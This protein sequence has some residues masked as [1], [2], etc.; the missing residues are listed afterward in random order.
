MHERQA[1]RRS[2]VSGCHVSGC[3]AHASVG[4]LIATLLT[5]TPA[6]AHQIH[7]FANTKGAEIQGELYARGGQPIRDARVRAISPSGETLG[8]TTTDAQGKFT[9]V[10]G[11]RCD[12]RLVA[13]S[14]DGHET[15]YTVP[16]GE[17]PESLPPYAAPPQP[18][19]VAPPSSPKSEPAD[20]PSSSA[21]LESLHNQVV[22][23]RRQL[24]GYEQ[25]I[26]LHDIL[27]GIGYIL[28]LMGVGGYF[29]AARRRKGE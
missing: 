19:T 10:A 17:L 23:L 9:L 29:L 27:G 20:I 14:G 12:H 15:E 26:R 11:S 24:D 25:K 5:A 6:A 16:A 18:E 21:Q 28:G 4:M 8:E 7:L 3:H 22:Q 1:S 2:H 13:D